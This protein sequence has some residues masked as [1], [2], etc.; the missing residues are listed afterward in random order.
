MSQTSKLVLGIAVLLVIALGAYFYWHQQ[1]AR[2]SSTASNPSEVTTLPTGSSTSDTSI[3]QDLSAIDAQIK[4]A[5]DDTAS[6]SAS[7]D[8]AAAQ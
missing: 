3:E 6:A 2:E 7:V 1:Q 4:S 5:H 8:A